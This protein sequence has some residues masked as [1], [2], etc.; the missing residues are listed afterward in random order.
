MN[1]E[2][3]TNEQVLQ[4]LKSLRQ[5]VAELEALAEQTGGGVS[6]HHRSEADFRQPFLTLFDA[7]R[8]CLCLVDE[9]GSILDVNSEMAATTGFSKDELIG[10]KFWELHPPEDEAS[11]KTASE[12]MLAGQTD[13]FSTPLAT[14]TG[15]PL[16]LEVRIIPSFLKD[17]KVFFFIGRDVT[18]Q[19]RMAQCFSEALEFGQK[20]IAASNLG[21]SAYN[22]EGRCVLTNDAAARIIGAT[23]EEVLNQNFHHIQSW[24]VSGL[25]ETARRTM[26]S[27][28][29]EHKEIHVI[30]SFGK[31]VWLDCRFVAFPS[32]GERHLL[33]LFDDITERKRA[34]AALRQSHEDLERLVAERT[35][36][37][38]QTNEELVL[39]INE[40]RLAEAAQRES[41]DR[42]RIL[43]DQ[44]FDGIFVHE[45]FRIVDLNQR[46]ADITGYSRPELLQLPVID[47]FTSDSQKLIHDYIRSGKKGYYELELR[48]KDGQI[49][50]IE[51]FGGPCTFYGRDARIVALR[52][53][54]ERKQAEYSLRQSETRFRELA[55]HIQE[56]FW[57]FDWCAQQVLY[58]SPAYEKVWGCSVDALYQDYSEWARSIYPDDRAFAQESFKKI[59]ETGGGEPR[60][61]R[62]V[63]PDNTVRW[64][65]DRG[66]AVYGK[67]GD[68]ERIVGLAEDITARKEA[69]EALRESERRYSSLF[70]NNHAVMLLID[71]ATGAIVDA[72]PAACSFYGYA[73]E[74]LKA[75][76]ISEIN[77]LSRD[78]IFRE[79]QRARSRKQQV[80]H[81]RHRLASGEVRD[82]EV[83]SGPIQVHS[84]ELLYSII[85]DITERRRVEEALH[86]EKEKYRILAEESPL[87]V[88][89]IG[90]D[91]TYHYL[92][93]KFTEMFGYT[94]E[95]VPSGRHWFAKAFPEESLR[96]EVITTWIKDIHESQPNWTRHRT[97]PVVC[98]N[99]AEKIVNFLSVTLETG[100]QFILYEDIT[101]RRR[102]EEALKQSEE[103][104]RS[105]FDNVSV[106]MAVVD[107]NGCAL[108]ANDTFCRFLDYR[109]DELIGLHF[110]VV[111][112]P[113]DLAA[114][115]NLYD[116]LLKGELESYVI[117]KRYIRKDGKVAWGCLSVSLVRN[118]QGP[119]YSVVACE[120]ITARKKA[121]EALKASEEQYRLLV[122][123]IPAVVFRGYTDCSVDFFDDKIEELTGYPKADFDSRR[124]KWCDV[125]VPEDIP[126]FK[127]AAKQAL[128]TI[129][130]YVREYRIRDKAG[131][132]RWLQARVQII[133][134]DRE[135]IDYLTGVF[136]DITPQKEMEEALRATKE[137]LQFLLSSTPA[138]I[139]S[140]K[141]EGDFPPTFVSDNITAQ[142]GY[143]PEEFLR[144]PKFWERH[145]HPDDLPLALSGFE[146]LQEKGYIS[147]DYRFR[148]RDGTYRWMHDEAK[149][150]RGEPN[151]PLEIVG[152]MLDITARKQAEEALRTYQEHLEKLVAE[153]T[154]ALARA[155]AQLL[156][157]IEEYRRAKQALS[158]SEVRLRTIFEGAPIGIALRE[159]EG[160]FLECNPALTRMIGYSQEELR[161]MSLGLITHPDDE[162]KRHALFQDMVAGNV[163]DYSM[164]MRFFKK[165]G[166]LRW[167]HF[168]VALI[169]EEDGDP[170]FSLTM[171]QDITWEKQAEEE[172]AS[173][174]ENLRSLASELSLT[175]ERERRRLAEFLHDEV[176]QTLA[177][178]KIKLGGLQQE[179]SLS[180]LVHQVREVRGFLEQAIHSTRNLT[181]E[182]SLPIL[183]EM[184]LEEAV[185]WLAEQFQSQY[186][187]AITVSRDEQPKPLTEGARVLLFRLVRELLTNVVKHAQA[188]QAWISFSKEN[189]HLRIQLRDDG[190]GFDVAEK[191]S[192]GASAT[193][194]GLFSVRERLSHLGG[195]LEV[196]SAPGQGTQVTITVPLTKM[197]Q[198]PP[199]W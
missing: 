152:F 143:E 172:L 93:P 25:L 75:K 140:C 32:G 23:R 85:H 104:F 188:R 133:C 124:L 164:D 62:I 158:E 139:Y 187:I 185:D 129:R 174:Q 100:D 33:L 153:R 197:E 122:K 135:K 16:E 123:S 167:G 117:D 94:L 73:R 194:F 44:S 63:R 127:E 88:A 179:L 118:E 35:R 108:M 72:N 90:K 13:L 150:V 20:I 10:K 199:V 52:D 49:V 34:E 184:G 37:L 87:G 26:A 43:V 77:T 22:A 29:E 163:D 15:R 82:V 6:P 91:G 128:K 86:R 70:E 151:Q 198:F 2:N 190:I 168:H 182:L 121:E 56:V 1:H 193:G 144:E 115:A 116:S 141:P 103:R 48:R 80:F 65:S 169:R 19:K 31:E 54:T 46:M 99:G 186:D 114:D 192:F 146:Q 69:E 74:E 41:E 83:Y 170:L 67:N 40:R 145:I 196:H 42:F 95:D 4:E 149:L 106:G 66:F 155:N 159:P 156:E 134:D 47:L 109:R 112:H 84:R 60:E 51:S 131:K 50:Q 160:R 53:I 8:D 120:D 59:I 55:E 165:D 157:K 126:A 137:R 101:E 180:P 71:P 89:I 171:V 113:D 12:K 7:V 191:L 147:Y 154:D 9:Q 183:Y 39:E 105:I 132:I 5:R 110:S 61:Y 166:S 138:V 17:Q 38:R 81:F 64:V 119:Q 18:A 57:I 189:D 102:A 14:K 98:K 11:P 68:V 30:S 79:M 195:L 111:T 178:T 97:F 36:D 175:E 173:Y 107:A 92:N 27:G 21:I 76:K 177:L 181:F 3:K 130:S 125:I 136:F 142:L 96:K 24:Q 78:Q 28:Q 176:G 148:H 45:N 162:P 58:V 161:T